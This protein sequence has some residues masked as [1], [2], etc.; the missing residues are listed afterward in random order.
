ML[1]ESIWQ[2]VAQNLGPKLKPLLKYYA[3]FAVGHSLWK[4]CWRLHKYLRFLRLTWHLPNN[5]PDLLAK[6]I[7]MNSHRINE[8]NYE[9]LAPFEGKPLVHRPGI[10]NVLCCNTEESIKW[11]LKDEFDNITKPDASNDPIFSLLNEFIGPAIFVLRHGDKESAEHLKWLHQRKTASKIFTRNSVEID[12]FPTFVQKSNI[13]V[14]KLQQTA[15]LNES[16][17]SNA[18][19]EGA[20]QIDMQGKFFQFTFDSI[21]RIFMGREIDTVGTDEEDPYAKAFDGAHR[22]M[23]LYLFN[24]IPLVL[25][26]RLLLPYPFGELH[27]QGFGTSVL[28]KLFRYFNPHYNDFQENLTFLREET[29]QRV[30]ELRTDPNMKSRNDLMAKFLQVD[31]AEGGR[32]SDDDLSAIILNLVIAGR[33]TTACLLSWLFYYLSINQEVQSKLIEELETALQGRELEPADL[34]GD[35]LPYLNGCIFEAVRLAPPV[36]MNIKIASQDVQFHETTIPAGTK[37]L[38]SPYV[39]GRRSSKYDNPETFD[40]SRWIPFQEPS[41]YDFPAWQAGNRF[42]LGVQMSRFEAACVVAS[43]FKKP[44]NGRG[45]RFFLEESQHGKITSSVMLTMSIRND[46]DQESNS[47]EH[48]H[49]LYL[50]PRFRDE[51]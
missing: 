23:L 10:D 44:K 32:L 50:I 4:I 11:M 7:R 42:C 36:P 35:Q 21:Q 28:L 41:M 26:S 47:V 30:R 16:V 45:L 2:D 39:M 51:K 46:K 12:M 1:L 20:H 33:D 29:M 34:R 49:N 3:I 22:S 27:P 37:L 38:Y 18:A 8:W 48:T 17:T 9:I 5:T 6:G 13:L 15:T 40:P 24:Q 19:A 31:A 43:V 14:A 25:V